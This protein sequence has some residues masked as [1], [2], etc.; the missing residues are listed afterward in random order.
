MR[1][2]NDVLERVLTLIA[3][4]LFAIF[5]LTVLYQVFARS[6]LAISVS[7]TDEI[8]MSCFVW[9]VFLGAAV[10]LRRRQHYVVDVFPS[11]FVVTQRA[12]RLFGS[13][14]C[15]PV[16]YVL[17]VNGNVLVDMGWHRRSVALGT[18][19]SYV[20]AAM[21]VAGVAMFLFSI[22][23]LLKDIKML[24]RGKDAAS[25]SEAIDS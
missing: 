19:M 12:L 4:S 7:W 20:F 15:L 21:P 13:I 24:A 5:I 18:P 3:G 6:V 1:L 22:E 14:A 25:Q 16:I 23:I 11:H 10:A 17:V 2:I 9:A 8:A